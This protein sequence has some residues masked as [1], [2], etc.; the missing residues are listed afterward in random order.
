MNQIVL[1]GRLAADPTLAYTP[2]GHAVGELR[3]AVRNPFRKDDQGKAQAD[4]FDIKVWR[5]RAEY[6]AT[7]LAKGSVIAIHGRLHINQ[8]T[9]KEGNKRKSY[10]I[11][12]EDVE[13]WTGTPRENSA[14]PPTPHA[15][16]A[17]ATEPE[18]EPYH[19]PFADQ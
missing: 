14:P 2:A 7:Y 6:C 5:Q 19:D 3:I 11:E 1:V 17:R 18:P 13:N 4:F 10:Y 9:D 16:A 12:A 15:P 8:W